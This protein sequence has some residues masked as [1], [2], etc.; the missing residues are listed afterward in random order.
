MNPNY[1]SVNQ[2]TQKTLML[3]N[4]KYLKNNFIK[5]FDNNIFI[6]IYYQYTFNDI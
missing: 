4:D 3:I 1:K 5:K 6:I 2:F